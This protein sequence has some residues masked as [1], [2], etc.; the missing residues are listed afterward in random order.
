MLS[1]L[2]LYCF[3]I[4]FPKFEIVLDYGSDKDIFLLASIPTVT[5]EEACITGITGRCA[6]KLNYTF[7]EELYV[8]KF[9]EN[10]FRKKI[11]FQNHIQKHKL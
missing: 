10:Y 11:K 3:E 6:E 1:P 9:K 8:V 2:E 4:I 7:N 5:G